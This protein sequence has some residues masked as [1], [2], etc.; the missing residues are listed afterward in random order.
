MKLLAIADRLAVMQAGHI[1]QVG[2]GEDLYR[3]PGHPFVAEFLGRVN[4]MQVDGRQSQPAA[5]KMSVGRQPMPGLH[6]H[7]AR[8]RS[9]RAVHRTNGAPTRIDHSQHRCILPGA[10]SKL[11]YFEVETMI[12]PF[13][14]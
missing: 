8:S 7:R 1:V 14:Q 5:L 10:C 12:R 4:R 9:D 6:R 2:R 11:L 13:A 3:Q